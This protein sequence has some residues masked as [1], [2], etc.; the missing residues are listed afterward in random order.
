[1]FQSKTAC[2]M[3]DQSFLHT[4]VGNDRSAAAPLVYSLV[5]VD[6]GGDKTKRTE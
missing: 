3:C 2:Y 6:N 1:M 5:N 4:F